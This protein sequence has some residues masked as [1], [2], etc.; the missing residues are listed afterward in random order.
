MKNVYLFKYIFLVVIVI[1]FWSCGSDDGQNYVE[2]TPVAPVPPPPAPESPVVLDFNATPFPYANLSEYKF[3]TGEMKNLEPAYEVLPYDLNSTLFT[4]YAHKKR[5]IW[6]PAGS[7]ATYDE[8]GKVLEFPSGT[9]LIKSFYYNNVQPANTTRIIETRLMIKKGTE[10]IFANYIWNNEQTEATLNMNGSFTNISWNEGGTIKTTDY[11]IPSEVE[12]FT[13]HKSDNAAIPIGPKP[14]NLNKIYPYITGSKNQLSKW[15]E[16]GYLADNLPPSIVSTVDWTD[17]AQPLETRVRSYLDINCA[18]C[19]HEGSHCDYR[20][21][22]FAFNET[23]VPQNLGICVPPDEVISPSLT[24]IV[25]KKNSLRS[26]LTYR[27]KSVNPSERMPLLGR[28]VK[29]EEAVALIEQWIN[30]M[31]APC[32]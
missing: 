11:R 29:H 23:T 13:C 16:E 5:F 2:V 18:H 1:S 22:R 32:P 17:E 28:T 12:C 4:D 8:D 24:Y 6:M 9:V 30:S 31:D 19:H 3:F 26:V 27:L 25:A 7:K 21:M 15:V 10:W 14:Q 20:A